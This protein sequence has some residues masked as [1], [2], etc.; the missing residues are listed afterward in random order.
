MESRRSVRLVEK[1]RDRDEDITATRDNQKDNKRASIGD[2]LG[3][4]PRKPT[5][6]N[7]QEAKAADAAEAAARQLDL[8]NVGVRQTRGKHKK[9][10]KSKKQRTKAKAS[11]E[12]REAFAA[13]ANYNP[14]SRQ[15]M[16]LQEQ[17]RKLLETDEESGGEGP[18]PLESPA[19]SEDSGEEKQE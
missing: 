2:V 17:T 19:P 6:A 16:A 14:A 8:F 5:G 11:A 13:G 10:R 12:A 18:P 9:K 3:L 15:S 7:L 1:K 4:T